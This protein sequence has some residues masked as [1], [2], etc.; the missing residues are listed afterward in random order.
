MKVHVYVC[1]YIYIHI[2]VHGL[3]SYDIL[4]FSR[5]MYVEPGRNPTVDSA[6]GSYNEAQC[7]LIGQ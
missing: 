5:P 2:H 1:I 6:L 4:S 3:S 7:K